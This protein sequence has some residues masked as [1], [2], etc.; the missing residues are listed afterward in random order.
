MSDNKTSDRK[1]LAKN[2]FELILTKYIVPLFDTKGRLKFH[3]KTERNHQLITI[4]DKK[5]NTS[6]VSF[7]PCVSTDGGLSPFHFSVEVYSGLA[8]KKRASEILRE[9]LKVAEYNCLDF[10]KQRDYGNNSGK[11]A[12]YKTCAF[13]LAFE[14]GM[15]KWLTGKEKDAV[16][17]HTLICKLIDWESKTY[18]GKKVPFGIAIDF[19]KPANNESADYISFLENDSSAVFGD[20]VFSGILLD[21]KGKLLSFL[22][23]EDGNGISSNHS[24]EIFAPTQFSEIAKKCSNATIGVIALANGEIIIIKNQEVCFSRRG[25]KWVAFDW[26]RVYTRLRPYFTSHNING[27]KEIEANIKQLYCTLLDVSFAHT[28]GCI[29]IVL[30]TETEKLNDII[31][32]RIDLFANGHKIKGISK[33]SYTKMNVVTNLLKRSDEQLKTFY[34]IEKPLRKELVSLDGAT[35]IS[36]KG[37]F[38][39]VGSIVSVPSGSSGGGRTA[40][41]KKLAS[42]GVG[43]KISEDGYIEAYGKGDSSKKSRIVPLFKFK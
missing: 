35:A 34:Q 43:I 6:V 36:L 40:A 16:T 33:E 29:S 8:L 32:E 41:A 42:I 21:C 23:G 17:L 15:C 31:K 12:K 1:K 39:C 24:K 14:L 26:N 11:K 9:L 22:S 19:N 5:D 13:D 27:E 28:G 25:S 3:N 18:E 4:L 37:E 38:Y 7:Y 2:E 20:G 30:P 10:S